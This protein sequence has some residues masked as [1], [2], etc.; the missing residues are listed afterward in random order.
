MK[1]KP[2]SPG[3]AAWFHM[4][5]PV[6][7]AVITSIMLTR[8]PVDFEAVKRLY[9]QRLPRFER[10]SQRV[11]ERG[12]PYATPHWEAMPD[13][14]VEQQMHHVA[15]PPPGDDAALTELI[16]DLASTPMDHARPLWDVHL[17][18]GVGGGSALVTRMHH[19]IA[20]GTASKLITD[21]L[22]G[23]ATNT[24]LEPTE[25]APAAFALAATLP[26]KVEQLI[27]PVLDTAQRSTRQLRDALSATVSATVEAASHPQETLQQGRAL[28][29][30][31][32][33]CW[34]ANCCARTTRRRR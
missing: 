6:N 27:A 10:F 11:V 23:T 24:P 22:F 21:T 5:G 34:P 29:W 18:D 19:C 4:D 20:D 3:D 16:S 28:R 32:P 9:K 30:R 15:L 12:L 1:L 26:G 13:F 8:T 2:M 7:T 17:V 25:E 31:A 14:S 33:A